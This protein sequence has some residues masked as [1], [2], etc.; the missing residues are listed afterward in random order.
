MEF[1][2]EKQEN[3]EHK[4]QGVMAWGQRGRQLV[5]EDTAARTASCC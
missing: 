1:N 4:S 3:E 5:Q 2:L